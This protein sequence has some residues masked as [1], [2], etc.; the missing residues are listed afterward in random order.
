MTKLNDT[1]IKTSKDYFEHNGAADDELFALCDLVRINGVGAVAARTFFEAGYASA[2]DVAS[3]NAAE[4]LAAVTAVNERKQYYKAK[5][6]E[7]DMQFCI[8]SAN[9]LIRYGG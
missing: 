6:G 9:L 3:A 2:A 8:D 5:L 4:M 7:K 1:G